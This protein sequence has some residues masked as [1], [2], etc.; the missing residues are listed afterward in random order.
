VGIAGGEKASVVATMGFMAA[1]VVAAN[2]LFHMIG[3]A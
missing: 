2:V 3:R 1:G